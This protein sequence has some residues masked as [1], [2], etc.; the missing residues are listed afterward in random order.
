MGYL[1]WCLAQSSLGWGDHLGISD[2]AEL[3]LPISCGRLAEGSCWVTDGFL[4]AAGRFV[5]YFAVS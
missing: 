1:A 5:H 4:P 2:P 3:V